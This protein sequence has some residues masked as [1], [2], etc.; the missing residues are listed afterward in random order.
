MFFLSRIPSLLKNKYL[1]ALLVFGFIM[2]FMDKNDLFT[3]SERRRQLR[4]LEESREHYTKAIEAEK[5]E[6]DELRN[7]PGKLEQYAR[8]KHLMKKE[9]EDLFLLSENSDPSLK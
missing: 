3:Q 6:L 9:N 4:E 5:K 8:E 7:N 1:I 2:L